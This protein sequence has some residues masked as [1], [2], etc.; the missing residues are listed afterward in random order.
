MERRQAI[1]EIGRGIGA[2]AGAM[3][4]GEGLAGVEDCPVCN[5]TGRDS[6]DPNLNCEECDGTGEANEG[7]G[8]G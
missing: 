2:V 3:L 8:P 6:F 4:P 5:G 7:H 1:K